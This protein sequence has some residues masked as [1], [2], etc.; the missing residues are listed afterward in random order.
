MEDCKRTP[1]YRDVL[2]RKPWGYEYLLFE[3]TEIALWYL[4]IRHGAQTSLHCHPRKKTGLIVLSG[5]AVIFFL[6]DSK[7]AKALTKLMIRPGLFHSTRAVSTD[8]VVVLEVETPGDKTDLVRLDDPYGRK[9]KPYEGPDATEPLPKNYVRLP[10]PEKG[11]PAACSMHGS[12]LCLEKIEEVSIFRH[13]EPSNMILV[14]EGGLVS[15]TGEPVLAAG[16][17]VSI[18]TLNRLA[19]AF[20]APDGISVMTVRKEES[21]LSHPAVGSERR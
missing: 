20:D 8:G 10:N 15:R 16:D 7:P 6:N 5:E 11:K 19:E 4:F 1:D 9:E 18:S 12:V 2:V 14:L 13:R 17:I 3:N 21:S